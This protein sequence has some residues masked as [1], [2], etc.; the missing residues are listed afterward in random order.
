[1]DVEKSQRVPPFSFFSALWDFFPKM[2]TFVFF[3]FFMFC[4]RMDVEKPQRVP[5]FSFS[6]LWDFSAPLGSVF[7]VCNFLEKFFS[8]NFDFRVLWKSTWHLEVFLLFLSLGYGADLGR[9]RLVSFYSYNFSIL[10]LNTSFFVILSRIICVGWRVR[11]CYIFSLFISRFELSWQRLVTRSEATGI[12]VFP[13][14]RFL[15][16]MLI[17]LWGRDEDSRTSVELLVRSKGKLHQLNCRFTIAAVRIN[18]S[19]TNRVVCVVDSL[20][21]GKW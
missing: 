13:F 1:M 5:P 21:L 7:W 10:E 4:D 17:I 14:L 15:G 8:K 12:S 6:A 16:K 3:N 20:S 9:S 2:K 18:G 11:Y 19:V